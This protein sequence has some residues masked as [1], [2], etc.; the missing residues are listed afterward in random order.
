MYNQK[1]KRAE[2]SRR[3]KAIVF[4]IVFHAL[5]FG[6]LTYGTQMGEQV[7]N[8]IKTLW[9]AEDSAKDVKASLVRK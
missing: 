5:L 1:F 8:K 3:T 2:K 9:K 6:G 4:T 7:T